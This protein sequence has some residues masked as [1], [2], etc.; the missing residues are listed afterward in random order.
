[1]KEIAIVCDSSVSFTK[2]EIKKYDVYVIPNLIIHNNKTYRDQVDINN[3]DIVKLLN[4][5]QK[6]TSSQANLGN[7]VETLERVKEKKYDHVFILTIASV[8]SGAH[9]SFALAATQVKLENYTHL[10]TQSVAGP[11]QQA[12]RAIREMNQSGNSIEEI[13]NYLEYLFNDQVSYLFPKSLDQIV[14]S[15][16][17]SKAGAKLASLLKIK[18]IV[19]L[20]PKSKSIEKLGIA[21]TDARA[22][23]IIVNHFKK[24]NVTPKDYDLYILDIDAVKEANKFKDYLF[25]KLG[26]FKHYDV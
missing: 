23:Q 17:V 4:K 14:A 11:V 5:K 6:L 2:E 10:D 21:R 7:I 3:N 13:T 12:V 26:E 25:K 15:G 22:F 9:N 1:M 18:P 20:Y 19:Y 24:H 8:L 16:R